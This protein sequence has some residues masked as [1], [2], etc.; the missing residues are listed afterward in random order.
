[1]MRSVWWLT[2]KRFPIS[3]CI[4]MYAGC[5]HALH[6]WRLED[7][8]KGLAFPCLRQGLFNIYCCVHQAS[9][10][11]A[12]RD[13]SFH[14]ISVHSSAEFVDGAASPGFPWVLEVQNPALVFVQHALGAL[15]PLPGLIVSLTKLPISF[16]CFLSSASFSPPFHSSHPSSSMQK[17]NPQTCFLC[18]T[19]LH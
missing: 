4:S 1:M 6:A 19:Y 11:G 7:N 9:C 5:A 12:F 17:L 15:H 10:L 16:S 8:L 13:C 2:I 14:F 18:F 3:L